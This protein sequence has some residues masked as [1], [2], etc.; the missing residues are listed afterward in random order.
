MLARS[1][2]AGMKSHKLKIG[3]TLLLVILFFSIV[4]LLNWT[5]VRDTIVVPIY[6]FL[7][8]SDLTLKSIPQQAYLALLMLISLIIGANTLMGMR[9]RHLTR[10][11]EET[12]YQSDSRYSY[13]RKLCSNSNSSPFARDGFAWEARK[14]ILSIFAYQ[15]EI[16]TAE[17]EARIR[18]GTLL[19]PDSI[20]KLI[21]QKKIQESK[22]PSQNTENTL[23]RLRRWLFKVEHQQNPQIDGPVAEIVDFI[24]HLLEIEHARK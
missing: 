9:A 16:E 23:L 7:W 18:N 19:V 10:S 3:L 15:N 22:L 14:L 13:W 24:E 20:L 5:F 4:T 17:V 2:E 11:L 21:Q 1:L 12:Q 6:Y 8:I